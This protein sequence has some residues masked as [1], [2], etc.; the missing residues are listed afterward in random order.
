MTPLTRIGLLAAML[1]V[2]YG[3]AVGR[4]YYYRENQ[5]VRFYLYAPGVDRVYFLSSLDAFRP[6]PARSV[7]IGGWTIRRPAAGEFRYF[8][9]LDG[10][11]YVPPCRFREKDDFGSENCVYQPEM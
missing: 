8:F 1:L 7:G 4:H 5:D 10:E 3:C 6:H 2:L 9:I 11:V